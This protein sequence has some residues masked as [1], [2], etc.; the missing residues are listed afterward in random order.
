MERKKIFITRKI[1]SIGIE[2]LKN[3]YEE[4]QYRFQNDHVSSSQQGFHILY[5]VNAFLQSFPAGQYN[6]VIKM[7]R[8]S[9]EY[10]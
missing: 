1:N 8:F 4:Q 3:Y 10:L 5:P 2:L 9:K 6:H 7:M